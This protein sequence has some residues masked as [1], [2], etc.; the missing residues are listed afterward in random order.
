MGF[1][2]LAVSRA[3][4]PSGKATGCNHKAD[5][6]LMT[7]KSRHVGSF[8]IN[9][10]PSLLVPK[11]SLHRVVEGHSLMRGNFDD[12]WPG[13]LGLFRFSVKNLANMEEPPI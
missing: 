1:S 5:R 11:F 13:P 7:R 12:F 4:D 2:I 9:N 8:E 6:V 10:Y 3:P